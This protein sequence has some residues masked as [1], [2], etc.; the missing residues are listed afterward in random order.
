MIHNFLLSGVS[1]PDSG[2]DQR[3][4]YSAVFSRLPFELWSRAET[5]DNYLTHISL[6]TARVWSISVIWFL[7]VQMSLSR[8]WL[9]VRSGVAMNTDFLLYCPSISTLMCPTS[10][11]CHQQSNSDSSWHIHKSPSSTHV[12]WHNPATWRSFLTEYLNL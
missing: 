4:S 2:V 1:I 5:K 7:W 12:S 11:V 8:W 9:L 6:T 3:N 10:G